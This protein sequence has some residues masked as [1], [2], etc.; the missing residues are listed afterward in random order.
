[1]KPAAAVANVTEA[2]GCTQHQKTTEPRELQ[3]REPNPD[4]FHIIYV[5]LVAKDNLR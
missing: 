1:M 5:S 2:R 3:R 4:L